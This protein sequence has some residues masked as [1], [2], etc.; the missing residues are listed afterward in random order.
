MTG[1][2]GA[3][4]GVDVGAAMGTI[5]LPGEQVTGVSAVCLGAVA[6]GPAFSRPSWL[7]ISS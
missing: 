4:R 5:V 1:G 7:S 3:H 2:A 6:S